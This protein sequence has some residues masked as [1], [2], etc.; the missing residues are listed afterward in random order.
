MDCIHAQVEST[1]SY[2]CIHGSA[3]ISMRTCD[4][5]CGDDR[6]AVGGAAPAASRRLGGG[7]HPVCRQF[8]LNGLDC[9]PSV[10]ALSAG[11]GKVAD[12][13]SLACATDAFAGSILLR[14]LPSC[15]SEYVS[16]RCRR[17]R[18]M[19]ALVLRGR[20]GGGNHPNQIVMTPGRYQRARSRPIPS[21]STEAA[22]RIA[23][24]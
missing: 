10:Q 24:I 1:L 9:S 12:G 8:S 14:I 6:L 3:S 13:S 22:S 19:D 16:Q 17:I 18:G 21:S 2:P 7:A 23:P 20:T 5:G 15:F 11:A 4:L